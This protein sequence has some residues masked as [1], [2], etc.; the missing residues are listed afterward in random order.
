MKIEYTAKFK[1]SY[2]KLSKK[3][4]EKI[5]STLKIF[6]ED[7]FDR[8]L[9]N[10]KL[11]GKYKDYRAISADHDLRIIYKEQSNHSIIYLLNLGT[12]AQVY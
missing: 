5:N 6:V 2:K 11:K 10:H 4:Q 8:R 1:K 12:Y 7:H 3:D 9:K